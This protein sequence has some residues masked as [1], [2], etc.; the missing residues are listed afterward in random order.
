MPKD[1]WNLSRSNDLI[2]LARL[3]ERDRQRAVRGTPRF[4]RRPRHSARGRASSSIRSLC[5]SCGDI[6]GG[7]TCTVAS[8]FLPAAKTERKSP[9]GF[10]PWCGVNALD[11]QDRHVAP[12]HT[13]RKVSQ[14]GSG[15]RVRWG[16]NFVQSGYLR[17]I[18]NLVSLAAVEEQECS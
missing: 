6:G 17:Q 13:S 7:G 10:R 1:S 11:R 14:V 15:F 9:F 3:P 4:H 5:R 16:D 8:L 12:I 18:P 2:L